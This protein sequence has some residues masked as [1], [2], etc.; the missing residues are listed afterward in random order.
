MLAE[1]ILVVF[2]GG[3]TAVIPLKHPGE[4]APICKI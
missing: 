4:G 3:G 2:N 1:I